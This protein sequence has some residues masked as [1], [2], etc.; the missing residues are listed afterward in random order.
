[1]EIAQ[2]PN[3]IRIRCK[4]KG[5]SIAETLRVAGVNR[6]LIYD[7][8]RVGQCPSAEVMSNLADALDCSVDYL[9]GRTDNPEINK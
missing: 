4:A 2:I 3:R 5:V 8:E 9:L 6:N 7:V 1:V